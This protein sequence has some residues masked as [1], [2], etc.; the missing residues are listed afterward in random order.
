MEL[1]RAKLLAALEGVAHT[2]IILYG[3]YAYGQPGAE[4][5]IDILLV[6]DVGLAARARDEVEDRLEQAFGKKVDLQVFSPWRMAEEAPH[7]TMI[8]DAVTKGIVL[9]PEGRERSIYEALAQ[10]WSAEA[11]SRHYLA[12][13]NRLRSMMHHD[14]LEG[15]GETEDKALRKEMQEWAHVM[16]QSRAASLVR[17]AMWALLWS[18]DPTFSKQEVAGLSGDGKW[19]HWSLP[20]LLK[21]VAVRAPGSYGR[22]H[23]SA[24]ALLERPQWRELFNDTKAAGDRSTPLIAPVETKAMLAKAEALLDLI[25]LEVSFNLERQKAGLEATAET[26]LV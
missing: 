2:E 3:S 15:G 1:D 20:S 18:A 4:S 17:M 13:A 23:K 16:A 19:A 24:D 10:E 5:D 11:T 26:T 21:A 14:W 22:V 6:T 12:M 9:L 7:S 8:P 25:N